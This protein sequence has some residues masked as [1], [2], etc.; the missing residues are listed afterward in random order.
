MSP[1]TGCVLSDL[2]FEPYGSAQHRGDQ[3]A[4]EH[5]QER[6]RLL[7]QFPGSDRFSY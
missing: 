4:Y 5:I 2:A 6:H 3:Y 1:E 7:P